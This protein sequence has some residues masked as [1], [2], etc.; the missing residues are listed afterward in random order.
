MEKMTSDL[1]RLLQKQDFKSE[2]ELKSYLDGIVK[3]GK[4]PDA[5]PKSAVQFAQDIM[6]FCW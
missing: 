3:G 2:A 1:S 5:P 6:G 4:I